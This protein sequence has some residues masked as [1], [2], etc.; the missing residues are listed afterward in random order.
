MKIL[1]KLIRGEDPPGQRFCPL[2]NHPEPECFIEDLNSES[3]AFALQYCH[4][5]FKECPIYQKFISE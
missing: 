4:G 2:I 3:I 1:K 5:N